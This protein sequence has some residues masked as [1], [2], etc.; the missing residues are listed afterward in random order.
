MSDEQ[1]DLYVELSERALNGL[2]PTWQAVNAILAELDDV[3][4]ELNRLK[5]QAV[6]AAR[7]PSTRGLR[8]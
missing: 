4:A 1:H 6:T 8:L 3:R 2:P 5:Q 7:N